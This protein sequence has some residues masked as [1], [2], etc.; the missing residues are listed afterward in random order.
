MKQYDSRLQ[1]KVGEAGLLLFMDGNLTSAALSPA[2]TRNLIL[3]NQKRHETSFTVHRC[4]LL[5]V[6][7]CMLRDVVRL[8]HV[9]EMCCCSNRKYSARLKDIQ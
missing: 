7:F 2:A 6:Y 9:D 1:L 4:L 3:P 5:M 8:L